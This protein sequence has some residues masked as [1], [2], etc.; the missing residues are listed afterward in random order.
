LLYIVQSF[1]QS[2]VHSFVRLV[3]TYTGVLCLFASN[4]PQRLR[5]YTIVYF[6]GQDRLQNHFASLLCYVVLIIVK[7]G[8]LYFITRRLRRW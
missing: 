8:L 7:Y 4:S 3:A 5:P 1:V 6:I 2:F